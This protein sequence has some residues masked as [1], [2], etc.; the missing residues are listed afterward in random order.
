MRHQRRFP[1]LVAVVWIALC[2]VM[3][4]FVI[5]CMA[6]G[7]RLG[8][9]QITAR[10]SPRSVPADGKSQAQIRIEVRDAAG[11]LA[12]DGTTVVVSTDL[13][14]VG[15][16]EFDRRAQI[17]MKTTSGFAIVFATSNTPGLAKINISVGIS[18]S[19]NVYIEF[20]PE[21]E[22]ATPAMRVVHIDGG[23]VGYAL[24]QNVI[25]ARDAASVEYGGMTVAGA[26]IVQ[27]DVNTMDLRA[28]PAVVSRDEKE[29]RGES[30]FFQLYTKRGA[31]RQF[32][33]KGLQKLSFDLYSMDSRSLD[34]DL[35]Q[36]AFDFLDVTAH[37]W[38]IADSITVFLDEKI[39][40]RDA[41][42]YVD[43]EKV[44]SLPAYW[45][46]ALPGY[47][48]AS[49]SQILSLSSNGDL[50]VNFPFFYRVT[51]TATGAIEIQRGARSGSVIAHEG[52]GLGLREEYRGNNVEGEVVLSGLPRS[53]W[54]AEWHE[55]RPV[56]GG[57]L[58]DFSIGWPD[59]H[60]LFADANIFSYRGSYR[61]NIWAY[62][63]RPQDGENSY[64]ITADWLT[65]PRRLRRGSNNTFRLGTSVGVRHE[66]WEESGLVF[67]NE[68]YGKLDFGAWRL[69]P[70]TY[71]TFDVEDIYYWNTAAY[72]ANSARSTLTLEKSFGPS[73]TTFLDYDVEYNSGDSYREGWGQGLDLTARATLDRWDMYLTGRWDLTDDYNYGALDLIYYLNDRWRLALL[74]THY[75]LDDTKFDDIELGLGWK[76]W[77]QR[78]IGLRWSQETGG[79]SL[80]LGGLTSSF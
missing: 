17:A 79:V 73:F 47:R 64:G 62:Y 1:A 32:T 12:P 11:H 54:G 57:M 9:Y 69:A 22:A 78:E 15:S 45:V 39:V 21:G 71:L 37:T 26:D 49:H 18:R 14:E 72:G 27:F 63:R 10:V 55:T 20:R 74:G 28:E 25:E 36:N 35:P 51:D 30:L 52:W 2:L 76:V 19:D 56:F 70:Q 58:G 48:G 80:E 34:S 16:S 67:D 61:S 65:S 24:E 44:I 50:A 7:G 53:D 38:L 8:N 31:L 29:L 77:Q 60:S 42:I 59:H 46:L 33:D 4:A 41:E 75:K 68:L 43:G 3:A 6:Q 40:L 23:W 5:P 13:G 66:D